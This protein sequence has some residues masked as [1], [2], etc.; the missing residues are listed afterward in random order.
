M[1]HILLS[2]RTRNNCIDDTQHHMYDTSKLFD[3]CQILNCL[4]GSAW[5]DSNDDVDRVLLNVNSG[6]GAG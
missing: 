4:H 1:D 2:A 6:C 3:R 5:Q